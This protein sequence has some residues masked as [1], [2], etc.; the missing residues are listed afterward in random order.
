MS[1]TNELFHSLSRFVDSIYQLLSK[2]GK[3]AIENELGEAVKKK[4]KGNFFTEMEIFQ[5][6]FSEWDRVLFELKNLSKQLEKGD[7]NEILN[8]TK[9]LSKTVSS[10]QLLIAEILVNIGSFVPGPIGIV[11]SIVLAIGCFAVGDIPG[12]FMNLIGAIPF[13]KCAKYLPKIE[14]VNMIRNSGLEKFNPLGNLINKIPEWPTVKISN[15]FTHQFDG[16]VR[17]AK[18]QV[19]KFVQDTKEK[20][21]VTTEQNIQAE[22]S[23]INKQIVD[24]EQ[25]ILNPPPKYGPNINPN[26]IRIVK[27][28]EFDQAKEAV[29]MVS[30]SS[31]IKG[32]GSLDKN[33]PSLIKGW[34]STEKLIGDGWEK[35]REELAAESAFRYIFINS[36]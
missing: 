8:S 15:N 20:L 3:E 21:K 23:Q 11:C 35:A 13:A 19:T 33:L 9:K 6:I 10:L 28:A 17:N 18:N 25:A 26:I 34:G 4:S 7:V 29:S 24:F 2:S 1:A 5:K 30:N 31:T 32:V 12:G 16:V 27:N 36:H 14:F 22:M